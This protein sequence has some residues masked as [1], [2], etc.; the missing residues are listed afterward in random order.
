MHRNA[1]LFSLLH[2]YQKALPV[3]CKE[4]IFG[5]L[6]L[7]M[8]SLEEPTD[9]IPSRD[10]IRKSSFKEG[11]DVIPQRDDIRKSAQMISLQETD[12]IPLRDDIR[13]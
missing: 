13:K 7:R 1:N 9:D 6:N 8:T 3:L 12:V 5:V 2:D 11:T 10:V 4:S